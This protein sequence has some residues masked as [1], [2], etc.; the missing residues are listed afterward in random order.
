[1]PQDAAE[2]EGATATTAETLIMATSVAISE[3]R[4][5]MA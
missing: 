5:V 1:M 3:R 2:A 4:D